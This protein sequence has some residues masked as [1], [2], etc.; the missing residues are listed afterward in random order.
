MAT[1]ERHQADLKPAAAASPRRGG[2]VRFEAVGVTDI[3]RQR[4]HNEDH[5]LLRPELDLFVVADGMGGHNAGDIASRLATASLRNFFEAV[6]AGAEPDKQFIEG[7]GD[8]A[9]EGQ[10]LA[11]AIRK[12]NRDVFEISS[13]YRQ[14]H[15]MGST[16]VACYLA[17]AA[18]VMHI[19]HVGDSRCYRYRDGKLQQL[20]HDHS[21]INDALA[22][23]PDLT[24]E[25]LARLP[26][27]IITRALGMRED[28][29]VDIR[30]DEVQLGD[31]Y[32]L[33]SDGLSGM[34]EE[35]DIGNVLA[36]L[37]AIEGSDL[38]E[39]CETLVTLANDAGGTDNITAILIRIDELPSGAA[40]PTSPTDPGAEPDDEAAAPEVEAEPLERMNTEEL[41]AL[42]G[43]IA[44][45][46]T[47]DCPKCGA[48]VE[49]GNAFCTEC[50]APMTVED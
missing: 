25:E 18:G 31:I 30:S 8:L 23:K 12:A 6:S 4:K 40:D 3:G 17:R 11:A 49:D 35:E 19:G 20:T 10:H 26:K 24:Q 44:G 14:H 7:Y 47:L 28:V 42:G 29:K 9:R 27:N 48:A 16:V 34:V 39:G 13:T 32:L 5:V 36:A 46:P 2:D 50:G 37:Y 45:V 15:G 41:M 1:A 21:L 33:C 38:R 43:A 22:L